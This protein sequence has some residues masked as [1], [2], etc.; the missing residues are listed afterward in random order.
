MKDK[1]QRITEDQLLLQE[2][3][4]SVQQAIKG[5]EQL[6]ALKLGFKFL[7]YLVATIAAYYWLIK[8]ES[9]WLLILAYITFGF[10]SLLFAFNFAHDLS[11][12]ALFKKK[13]QNNF[14][15]TL[16]YTMVGAHAEAW[17]RRHVE[18]HH[19]AP[20]VKDYDTDLQITSLI[21]V[22]PSAEVRW[23]H[24]FQ[25]FYAPL[26]YTTYSLYWITIKDGYVY[27]EDCMQEKLSLGY[28]LSFWGQK[29]L[30]FGY[31]LALP[32]YLSS[33][34]WYWLLLA[35]LLMHICQSVFLLFTF[36]ITHHVE[37]TAY[38]ETNEEGIIETSWLQ[39]QLKSSNDF[40]PFSELANFIFGGFNNHIAHHLFP[41]IN[42][43]HYPMVNRVLYQKLREKGFEPNKTGFFSGILSH[44]KHLRTMGNP[45]YSF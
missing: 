31:L 18:S 19:Y 6:G 34:A 10:A 9:P 32:I 15:Y 2:L 7:F 4:H 24:R 39:N 12:D 44:L 41:N 28:H 5:K 35:F 42:H 14:L 20:N 1:H 36:F 38:F 3:S 30:Y 23:Y 11:H 29:L 13:W 33:L 26:A 21:R 22:E 27:A 25:H 16:M 40:Y 43:I 45:E 8:A 17:K 37:A